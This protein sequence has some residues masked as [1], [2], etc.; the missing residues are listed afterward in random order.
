M[1]SNENNDTEMSYRRGYQNGAF[2]IFRAVEQFLDP[3]TREVVRTWIEKDIDGWRIAAL[4]S[5][6]PTWRLTNL[7]VLKSH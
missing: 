7:N 6:P 3:A 2:E 1:P 4:R 5:R